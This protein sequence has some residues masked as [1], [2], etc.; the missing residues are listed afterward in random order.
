MLRA[1]SPVRPRRRSARAACH[2]DVSTVGSRYYPTRAATPHTDR[3]TTIWF[4][5]QQPDGVADGNRVLADSDKGWFQLL[6]LS[7]PQPAFFDKTWRAGETDP[8]T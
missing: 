3:P 5:P 1:A 7:S 8:V 4:G 2:A 6:R